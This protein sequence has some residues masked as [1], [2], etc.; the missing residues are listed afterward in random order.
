MNVGDRIISTCGSLYRGCE[1]VIREVHPSS[2]G[3]VFEEYSVDILVSAKG[4]TFDFPRACFFDRTQFVR[5]EADI[6]REHDRPCR[7][8]NC[9][10]GGH[11]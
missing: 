7:E 3:R 1:G 4:E 5:K 9:T 8:C 11:S 2:L 10:L 6:G